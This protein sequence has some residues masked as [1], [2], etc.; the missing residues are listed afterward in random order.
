MIK[1]YFQSWINSIDWIFIAL[2]KRLPSRSLRIA[3]LRWRGAKIAKHVAMY[4]SV[5]VRNPQGLFIAEGCSIGPKVLLDARKG[6]EIGRN[7]TIAYDAIIW[8]LHH[9]MNAVDFHTCGAKT[10]I[11]DFAWICSRAILLPGI[12]IGKGAVVASGAVV[13]KD[14]DPYTIVAGIPAK[15]IGKRN[16]IEFEYSAFQKLHCI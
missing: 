9:D 14:V 11:D 10:T 15:S 1:S 5:E 4:A 16:L 2:L 7:V 6:L 3:L 8:T 13:T 12:H